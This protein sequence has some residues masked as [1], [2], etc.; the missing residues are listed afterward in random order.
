MRV[1]QEQG[2]AQLGL[3]FGTAKNPDCRGLNLEEIQRIN[4]DKIDWS[5][6]IKDFKEEAENSIKENFDESKFKEKAAKL[7]AEYSGKKFLQE[8]GER[9]V[10]DDKATNAF[11]E[12]KIKKFYRMGE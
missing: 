7:Q 5:E 11:V 10:S 4:W 2:R 6:V 9:M 8:R 3:S 1:I 12:R